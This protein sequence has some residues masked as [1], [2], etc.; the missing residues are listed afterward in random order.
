MNFSEQLK[1]VMEKEKLRQIDIAQ[2]TG[3]TGAAIS[4]YLNGHRVPH[5]NDATYIMNALGYDIGIY[6]KGY[7]KDPKNDVRKNG[8]G[9]ADPTAFKAITKVDADRERLQKLLDTIFTIC[10]YAGFHVEDRIT[11]LDRKTGKVWK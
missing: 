8:S 7:K 11:L 3:F 6:K 2:A 10:D 5:F 1:Y 9:C 4:N